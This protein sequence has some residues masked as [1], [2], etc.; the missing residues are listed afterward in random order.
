M[1]QD[2]FDELDARIHVIVDQKLETVNRKLDDIHRLLSK[3]EGA[4][5]LAKLLFFIVAP[6]LGTILWLKDHVRL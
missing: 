1:T 3:L 5:L 6:A 2:Q 4:G